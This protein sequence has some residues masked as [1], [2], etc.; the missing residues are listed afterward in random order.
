[1][2]SRSFTLIETEVLTKG[3]TSQWEKL[4]GQGRRTNIRALQGVSTSMT[5]LLGSSA[6]PRLRQEG[7]LL[8]RN[9]KLS[10]R[11]V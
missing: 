11:R 7:S 3:M 2:G 4:A 9:P 5:L 10:A 1:M 8:R 6:S